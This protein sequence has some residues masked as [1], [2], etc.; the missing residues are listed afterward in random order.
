[1]L[2]KI[3]ANWRIVQIDVIL[4][5]SKSNNFL[6]LSLCSSAPLLRSTPPQFLSWSCG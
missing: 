3:D 5:K 2:G 1:M 6:P 4:M